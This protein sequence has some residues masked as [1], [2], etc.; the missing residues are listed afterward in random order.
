[1]C[2]VT[3]IPKDN[4]HFILTSNR[5]EGT[6]RPKAGIPLL[7]EVESEMMLFPK[8][9]TGGGTWIAASGKGKLVCLLNGAFDRHFPDPPYRKSRGIILLESLLYPTFEEFTEMHDLND[10]E[11]FTL[12]SVERDVKEGIFLSEMRWDGKDKYF[13]YL[14]EEESHIWSS[15]TLYSSE[16]REKRKV[17]FDSFLNNNSKPSEAAIKD[18]HLNAGDGDKSYSLVM[19][20]PEIPLQTVSV[21]QIVGETEKFDISYHD[22]LTQSIHDNSLDLNIVPHG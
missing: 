7:H 11:P 14:S 16:K 1:M 8:D 15:A 5:D 19:E 17:W 10:I 9:P 18:F 21:T 4:G 2:T 12:I 20:R 13:V 6:K 3:Y 22:L